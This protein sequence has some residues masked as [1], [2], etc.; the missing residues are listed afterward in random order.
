MLL[1]CQGGRTR[2]LRQSRITAKSVNASIKFGIKPADWRRQL[3]SARTSR[4]P[5]LES[6]KALPK[7]RNCFAIQGWEIQ[8]AKR[9]KVRALALMFVRGNNLGIRMHSGSMI[10]LC[11]VLFAVLAGCSENP[12]ETE[13]ISAATGNS[14]IEMLRGCKYPGGEFCSDKCCAI[15]MP[16]GESSEAYAECDL[17]TGE[18]KEGYFQDSGC[19][20]QC[21]A[22]AQDSGLPKVKNLETAACELGDKCKNS[23]F[24][25]FQ[26]ELC[27]WSDFEFC[28]RGCVNSTCT[29]LCTPG[30][31][32]CKKEDLRICDGDGS[33]WSF[34]RT[35]KDGCE[36]GACIE[37][38]TEINET[39]VGTTANE[40][41]N[42][43]EQ[44]PGQNNDY[45]AD[46][47]IDVGNFIYD[48][49]GKDDGSNL[50]EE[51]FSLKNDC[52]YPV[53]MT[54]W[55]AKD[56]ANH[57]FTFP[58][59]NL[60]ANAEVTIRTGSG[61][62]SQTD[63]YWGSSNYIWN[64]GEDTLYLTNPDGEEVLNYSYP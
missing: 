58:S 47:C 63:L 44:Q 17:K 6:K 5:F 64:N 33:H 56:A 32:I 9:M 34:F 15:D 42:L 36:D 3:L 14:V 43:T 40:T 51:Q 19:S 12:D 61:T 13:E 29:K 48:A 50:N 23:S 62:N 24:R 38:E 10:L 31:F 49:P 55:I 57:A 1:Y 8:I 37:V 11:F 60:G 45:M 54:G 2:L 20:L 30:T 28:E 26:D 18:W 59:I 35:C 22:T 46:N 4:K 39:S 41:A 53:D 52:S 25:A 16:C 21:G 7:P 27:A